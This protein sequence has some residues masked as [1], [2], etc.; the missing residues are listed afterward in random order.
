M[1][2][3]HVAVST[4]PLLSSVVVAVAVTVVLPRP[5]SDSTGWLNDST[6][7]CSWYSPATWS[8]RLM[9]AVFVPTSA[10]TTS[11]GDGHSSTR[12]LH[13]PSKHSSPAVAPLPSSH[14]VPA[15]LSSGSRH[16]PWSHTES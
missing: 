10:V 6:T 5:N 2:N 8:S 7:S 15:G 1:S 12:P 11:S 9:A 4:A 3:E 16:T 13:S 14:V